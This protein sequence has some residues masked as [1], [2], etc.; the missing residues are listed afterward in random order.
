[1]A[2]TLY[3]PR[4]HADEMKVP[5][6]RHTLRGLHAA[7]IPGKRVILL[8]R[9]IPSELETPVLAHEC[10]HAEHDDPPGHHRRYESRADLHA[11]QRLI[12]AREFGILTSVYTDYDRICIELG[13]TREQFLAFREYRSQQVAHVRRVERIGDAVYVDPKMGA[14]QWA[15][16]Y[17]VA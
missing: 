14:G 4:E 11:A 10:D 15:M 13:V 17:E 3:D 12:D 9:N 1:M 2:Q 6:I 5:I 8:N 7:W 16:K